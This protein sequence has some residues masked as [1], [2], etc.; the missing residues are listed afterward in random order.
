MPTDWNQVRHELDVSSNYADISN[1]PWYADA[2]Y[3]T[4]SDAEFSRRHEAARSLMARE[5]LDALILTGSPNIYSL[6][7]GVTWGCGLIDDRGMCQYLVLPREGRPTLI[8]PHDGCHLE[9]VR[10]M[11][12]VAEVRGG[13]KGHF[14][15]AIADRLREAGV[16]SGRVGVTAVDRTGP[17]YMGVATYLEL[18]RELPG[19]EI[20][21]APDLFH[22]LTYRKSDDELDAMRTAGRLAVAAQDAVAGAARPGVREY[23]LAAAGTAA[24]LAGGGR[25]H[26]MM[27][28]STPMERP[29]IMYPNPN[30]SRRVLQHG[31]LILTEIS[32]AHL[33]YSAKLGH[34]ITIGP[35][36]AE[37]NRFHREVTLPGFMALKDV[38]APG[39]ALTELQKVSDAFR[40]AGAQS[41][42]M[43]LHGIDLITAGP[44]VMVHG[45]GAQEYDSH[46]VDGMVVNVEATPITADGVWGSFLSRSYAIA[47]AGVEDLTPTS[48][49]LDELLTV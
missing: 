45:V 16:T 18:Q 1:T 3:D 47:S 27:I 37:M 42:P 36:T 30:P 23:E 10:R 25:V 32:A 9:A 48:Y 40:R 33:G 14:G 22:E 39:V 17:E 28:A 29:R 8:Y 44:K 24:I 19:V 13:Q 43:T 21:F 38:L 6:G 11:V 34:P 41:R 35:P 31:D 4:F 7:S 46:L 20:V 12:S 49:P 2:E 26:L 15:K 5:R